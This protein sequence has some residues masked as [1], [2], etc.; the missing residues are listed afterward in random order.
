M[1][2]TTVHEYCAPE[3]TLTAMLAGT[4]SV[5]VVPVLQ[6]AREPS[7]KAMKPIDCTP[8]G[9]MILVRLLQDLKAC[10]AIEVT[11]DGRLMP[12]KLVQ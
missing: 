9:I 10:A 7:P 5:A 11:P 8:V 12:D 3:Y 4:Y 6:G 2:V 1:Y